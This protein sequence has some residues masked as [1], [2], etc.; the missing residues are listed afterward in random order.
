MKSQLNK[1]TIEAQQLCGS[2]RLPVDIYLSGKKLTI[3]LS[4]LRRSNIHI[5]KVSYEKEGIIT[6]DNKGKV[7]NTIK[8]VKAEKA[9]K[10]DKKD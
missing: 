3:R 1:I 7:I 10:T 2:T 4:H 5:R 9:K 8:K 6:R